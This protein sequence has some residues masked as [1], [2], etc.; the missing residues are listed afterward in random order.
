M[1]LINCE[2][3][4]TLSWFKNYVLTRKTK[5]GANLDANPSIVGANNPRN[6]VFKVT[7]CKR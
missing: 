4:L 1:P 3:S 5:R 2:I 7:E 6:A